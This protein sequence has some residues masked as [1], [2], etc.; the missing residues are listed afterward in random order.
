MI[1]TF[2]DSELLIKIT[3]P[4]RKSYS[5]DDNACLSSPTNSF[6]YSLSPFLTV[7]KNSSCLWNSTRLSGD[8]TTNLLALKDFLKRSTFPFPYASTVKKTVAN[9]LNIWPSCGSSLPER[10]RTTA[11]PPDALQVLLTLVSVGHFRVM[12]PSFEKFHLPTN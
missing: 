6:S 3:Q 5:V 4:P 1:V 9:P 12:I 11:T 7:R 10:E 2:Y 8:S